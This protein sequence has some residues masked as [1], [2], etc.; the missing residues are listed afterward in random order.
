M[1]NI[2]SVF[3]NAPAHSFNGFRVMPSRDWFNDITRQLAGY[4]PFE[5]PTF[6][7]DFGRALIRGKHPLPITCFDGIRVSFDSLYLKIMLSSSDWNW[8]EF[9]TV[10]AQVMEA[11]KQLK[12]TD[13]DTSF[14]MKMWMNM[15]Y[16]QLHDGVI[17]SP[18]V[19]PETISTTGREIMTLLL[20]HDAAIYC[21]TDECYFREC[22]TTKLR[23]DV[24][25]MLSA[26]GFDPNHFT[27]Q[28][29]PFDW[30]EIPK[31]RHVNIRLKERSNT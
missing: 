31:L 16:G 18:S 1:Q 2:I 4:I 3:K 21:D 13:S 22:N 7:R 5:Y 9:P 8:V 27:Y 11:Q 29:Q 10:L 12:S 17:R 30:V 20:A 25:T 6:S 14:K 19:T 15:V 26:S 23:H 28:L 24:D